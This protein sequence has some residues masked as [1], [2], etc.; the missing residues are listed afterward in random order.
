MDK[1][2]LT[3]HTWAPK[4]PFGFTAAFS[5]AGM[6][7][8]TVFCLPGDTGFAITHTQCL[9]QEGFGEQ[10]YPLS[11]PLALRFPTGLLLSPEL[12]NLPNGN[13]RNAN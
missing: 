10:I 12:G 13:V 11:V 4:L 9:S 7:E 8:S 6:H 2:Y 5:S 3:S 1:A